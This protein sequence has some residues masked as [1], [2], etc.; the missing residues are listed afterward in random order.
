M[1]LTDDNRRMIND[2]ARML[3]KRTVT[4]QEIMRIYGVSERTA[5]DM[6]SEIA[7]R[8]PIIS[9]SNGKGYRR[10][11]RSAPEANDVADARHAYNENRK[12][13]EEILKRNDPIADFLDLPKHTIMEVK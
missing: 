5:R 8:V 10:I 9:L 3:L 13:A 6:V 12:R 2:L 11:N 1:V 4:K 7:K